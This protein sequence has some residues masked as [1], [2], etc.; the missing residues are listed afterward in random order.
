MIILKL[1]SLSVKNL[2]RFKK[3]YIL[4]II[5]LLVSVVFINVFLSF[6]V[7]AY[8]KINSSYLE[9]GNLNIIEINNKSKHINDVSYISYDEINALNSIDHVEAAFPSIIM[10]VP[11]EAKNN[12]SILTI[13][14]VQDEI[15]DKITNSSYKQIPNGCI[16]INDTSKESISKDL[17]T[18]SVSLGLTQKI[19][20]NTGEIIYKDFKVL[21]FYNSEDYFF[22]FFNL[23]TDVALISLDDAYEINSMRN[24]VD[25]SNLEYENYFIKAFV[26]VDDI[27]YVDSVVKQ[28]EQLNYNTSYSLKTMEEFP[29]YLSNIFSIGVIVCVLLLILTIIISALSTSQMLNARKN[30]FGI[31]QSLGFDSKKIFTILAFEIFILVLLIMLVSITL[32]VII[33]NIINSFIDSIIL[34]FSYKQIILMLIII[35]IIMICS[36]GV[37]IFKVSRSSPD[38]N[39][40]GYNR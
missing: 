16:L 34:L 30:E 17:I 8:N 9:N 14:G 31:L 10:Q 5:M 15:I 29:E 7:G 18:G 11:I 12:K 38:E 40:R 28:L 23:P 25:S 20:E 37:Q 36:T 33:V 3:Y 21:G 26:F 32:L 24:T 39:I 1:L 27:N 19:K 13:M 35:N 4:I 22:R 6:A 2:F